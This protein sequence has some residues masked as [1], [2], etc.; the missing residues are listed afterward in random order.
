MPPILCPPQPDGNGRL[1]A[2]SLALATPLLCLALAAC[3]DGLSGVTESWDD[4]PDR[5]WV[6]PNLWANRLQD[7][8]VRDGRLESRVALPMRTVHLLT[9]RVEPTSGALRVEV[10]LGSV[11]ESGPDGIPA[12]GRAGFLL[13]AGPGLDYRSAALI[14]HSWGQGG[15]L[16]AGVDETGRLF[17]RDFETESGWLAQGTE[18]TGRVDVRSGVT[19]SV[20]AVPADAPDEVNL[21]VSASDQAGGSARLQVG[22][23]PEDRLAGNVALVSDV[24]EPSTPPFWFDDFAASGERLGRHPDRSLGPI[25]GIQHTLSRGTL[26]LTAQLVPLGPADPHQAALETWAGDA[27]TEVARAPIVEPGFT[28]TFRVDAWD[29]SQDTRVRVRVEVPGT[30]AF[31]GLVPRDPTDQAEIVVAAFT[32]NHNVAKPVPGRWSGV[33]GGWFPW[34]WGVWFPHSDIVR[35]VAG[36]DPDLLFFSGD[37]VYEGASPTAPDHQ[38]PYLDYL[39]RWYLWHWAFSDLTRRLPSVS[40]PDDHD[41]YHGN[42]WGAGGIATPAGL[43]GAAAQDAGGY[44]MPAEFVRMVERTQTSHLPDPPDPAPV[45]QDIGVYF[46]DILYGGVSFAVLEDRK[47][48][49]APGPILPEAGVV[50]GWAQNAAFDAKRE[51]DAPGAML[52]GDR[53]LAFLDDWAGDWSDGTWMKVALS[54]TLFANLAT[55]PASETSDANVPTLRIVE[56]GEY[57]PD[58]R[59]VADM[60]SNGWPPSGRDRALRAMRRGFAVHLAGDQHLG[61]TLQY[62]IDTWEDA[63]FALCV[64]SIANFFPRRWFP[65]R[66][67]DGREPGDPRYAGRFEDGFGNRVTVHA[68]SNPVRTGREPGALHDMAPGYGVARFRRA[69]RRISLEAWPR[70]S[71][72]VADGVPYPGWPVEFGQMEGHGGTQVGWLPEL[73]VSGLDDPVVR[74]VDEATGEVVYTL[75]MEGS[76]FSAPAYSPGPFKVG[77]GEPGTDRWVELRG[78]VPGPRG[79]ASPLEVQVP[80]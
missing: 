40:I 69:D 41:V 30:T 11:G 56:P 25:V 10:R 12:E 68:V 61:S 31:E 8:Q 65:P 17:V 60:D 75:R 79:S 57:P 62:G 59:L 49:S 29:D 14:H 32:G 13:G 2:P 76:R 72:P 43:G 24:P 5:L 55:L 34:D 45:A 58:D 9:A 38:H 71:D 50:N 21:T 70:W 64:P 16:F 36:Q 44:K 48:K 18:E 6:G 22:G 27:W 78:V 39:Y 67:G 26:K 77:V 4:S 63:A 66:P 7:W 52:L 54:Q 37:Q 51:S 73:R 15:G 35:H 3:G 42:V 19:L 53:Q 28:A 47:F 80:R 1:R 46:T 33:D 74:L 20:V 23:I